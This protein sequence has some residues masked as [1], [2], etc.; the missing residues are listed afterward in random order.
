MKFALAAVVVLLMNPAF[1]ADLS[2]DQ[3][4][5]NA[6]KD[7]ASLSPE[8]SQKL[9]ESQGAAM[10]GVLPACMA[11]IPHPNGHTDLTPFVVVMQLDASGKIVRTWRHGSTPLATCFEH[12]IGTKTLFVPPKVPFYTSIELALK[13][14]DPGA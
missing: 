3:A 1:A 8:L 12:E 6:D 2:Y 10:G 11:S 14:K 4:K 13:E 5:A 7:E 9:V